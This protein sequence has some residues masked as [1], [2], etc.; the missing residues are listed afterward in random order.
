MIHHGAKPM[1]VHQHRRLL[2]LIVSSFFL[3]STA[4][5]YTQNYELEAKLERSDAA[6]LAMFPSKGY[7]DGA[8]GFFK[9]QGFAVVPG[10]QRAWCQNHTRGILKPGCYVE[11]FFHRRDENSTD[12]EGH[13]CGYP[14]RWFQASPGGAYVPTPGSPF[15][16]A[17]ADAD[18]TLLDRDLNGFSAP[19]DLR[20]ARRLEHCSAKQ[21]PH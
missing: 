13:P 15:A 14:G 7:K 9:A 19:K 10:S 17:I 6:V 4:A 1:S 11:L 18:P 16:A 5:A 21:V 3:A 20:E 2:I 12:A 8:S